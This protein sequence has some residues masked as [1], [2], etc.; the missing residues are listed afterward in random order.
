MQKIVCNSSE[1]KWENKLSHLL[2]NLMCLICMS[3]VRTFYGRC[4][5]FHRDG[6]KSRRCSVATFAV[7]LLNALAFTLWSSTR[8][9]KVMHNA[10]KS[11]YKILYK[12]NFTKFHD[13]NNISCANHTY[14]H[15][16]NQH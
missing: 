14:L 10:T 6:R 9:A 15:C 12:L 3:V 2:L 11:V 8:A 13:N 4:V 5:L 16:N 1:I 7:L